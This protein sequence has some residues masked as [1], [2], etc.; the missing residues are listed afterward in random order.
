MDASSC[1]RIAL[2]ALLAVARP[3]RGERR[4]AAGADH[5]PSAPAPSLTA[6]PARAAAG[7]RRR[8]NRAV[9]GRR[10]RPG[11]APL[12]AVR[13]NRRAGAAVRR[14]GAHP[15][16]GRRIP[17]RRRREL[18]QDRPHRAVRRRRRLPP[19]RPSGCSATP[20]TQF[21][22]ATGERFLSPRQTATVPAGAA[23]AWCSASSAS[24][25]AGSVPPVSSRAR[26][27][28]AGG[29]RRS[30]PRHCREPGP[31]ARTRVPAASR[32]ARCDHDPRPPDSRPTS[33]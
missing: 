24:T 30:R 20:L 22:S 32:R 31:R 5:A 1:P 11:L 13:A 2:A 3:G 16:A 4:F 18:G 19:P 23:A 6:D 17:P 9:R 10:Q 25:P 28:P 14:A 7:R 33:T 21:R 8:R 26:T 27:A 12:R 15:P 29:S